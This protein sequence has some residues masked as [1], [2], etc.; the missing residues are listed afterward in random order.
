MQIPRLSI[1]PATTTLLLTTIFGSVS[2]YS[3][4]IT[5]NGATSTNFEVGTNWV[6]G[7][8][9]ADSVTTDSA[10]FSGSP[11]VNQPALTVDRSIGGLRF[12]STGG[13]TLGGSNKLTL[14]STLSVGATS[15]VGIDASAL[16]SGSDT[17]GVGTVYVNGSQTWLVGTGGTLNVGGTV[18]H[19]GDFAVTFGD[20]THAGTVVLGDN[21][22]T[23]ADNSFLG[24]IVNGGT[25]VLNK[26]SSG[27]DHALSGLRINS[28]GTVQIAG[29]GGQQIY[30][31]GDVDIEAGGKLDLNGHSELMN[32]LSSFDSNGG[33][34]D[35][36]SVSAATLTIGE[37][38]DRDFKGTIQNTGGALSLVINITNGSDQKLSGAN[39]FSGGVTIKSGMLKISGGDASHD[40]LGTGTLTIGDAANTGA[41]ATLKYNGGGETTL[42]NAITVTGT[43]VNT[44][45][46][47][48][49]NPTFTGLV[50]FNNNSTLV[51]SSTNPSGSTIR[52]NGG[53]AGTG[54]LVTQAFTTNGGSRIEFNGAAVNHIG[55]ITN[56][57][58][59]SQPTTFNA[60]I[61]ANVTGVIQDSETSSLNLTGTNSFTSGILIKSG[62]VNVKGKGLGD[63]DATNVGTITL[64]DVANT[65]KSATLNINGSGVGV[66]QDNIQGAGNNPINV[67]GTGTRTVSVTDW[68]PVLSGAITL[69]NTNLNFVSNNAAGSELALNGNISG[70]GNLVIQSNAV[71]QDGRNS[72]ITLGGSSINNAGTITN[73]GTGTAGAGASIDTTISGSI[74]S[75]VTGVVQNSATSR[76][77]L[78]GTNTYAGGTQVQLGTLQTMG[79]GNLGLGNVTV[80]AGATLTLGNFDSINNAANLTVFSSSTVNLSSGSGTEIIGSLFSSTG[81]QYVPAG[82]YTI[83]DLN[84]HFGFGTGTF[85]GDGSF[86]VISSVPEPATYGLAVASLLATVIYRRRRAVV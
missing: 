31:G 66:F 10:L 41:A 56:N 46:A 86:Q 50:T 64:G 11:T 51:I 74:G 28:G 6:S 38:R 48:D 55:T 29:S 24:A 57:G 70:T 78:S 80:A 49:W 7:T 81:N 21:V 3:A 77:I 61:G 47:D 20:S 18:K 23:G 44:L 53:T 1:S 30:Q 2:A 62:T 15:N 52:M 39:T 16:T 5:W 37:G 65:G 34:V 4:E 83:S 76:L 22:T 25:L 35:N 84:N 85:S 36:T 19:D 43:G 75:N 12:G 32:N 72:R 69:N 59:G 33:I 27:G 54:N 17:I 40:A 63:T 9:P 73:S 82:T 14:G 26:A 67:V 71:N 58:T 68:N 79:S 60:N 8:A 42:G 45:T 13:W